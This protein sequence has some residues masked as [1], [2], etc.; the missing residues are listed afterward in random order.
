MTLV[1]RIFLAPRYSD[2]LERKKT[3]FFSFQIVIAF[4]SFEI[5]CIFHWPDIHI[6][7]SFLPFFLITPPTDINYLYS[8]PFVT[9]RRGCDDIYD[10]AVVQGYVGAMDVGVV[11][12]GLFY[13]HVITHY[14]VRHE[15]ISTSTSI[16]LYSL[17]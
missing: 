12:V 15:S 13:T 5:I 3:I 9:I 17:I 2:C 8:D 4:I 14:S 7:V 11:H 1:T 10:K 16:T 6:F